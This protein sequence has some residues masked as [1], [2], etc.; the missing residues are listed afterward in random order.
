MPGLPIRIGEILE[1]LPHRFP[2]LLVDR[3]IALEPGKSI[4]AIKNVSCNE[5]FF[6]GHFPEFKIMPGVLMVEAI[7]Q[8][9]GVLLF[10]TLPDA[11]TK[12]VVLSKIDKVKFKR[13]VVPGDQLRMEA[14]ILRLKGRICHLHGRA[15][16]DGELVVEGE[17]IATILDVEDLHGLV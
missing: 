12:F 17:I 16:V 7:A 6:Q 11:K 3:V 4:V 2:F 13:M 8:A 10:N 15:L 9:G 14:E 1:F 5:H